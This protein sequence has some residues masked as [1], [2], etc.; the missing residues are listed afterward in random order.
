MLLANV[1]SVTFTFT[2]ELK[3][4]VVSSLQEEETAHSCVGKKKAS[5]NYTVRQRVCV[6]PVFWNGRPSGILGVVSL[7]TECRGSLFEEEAC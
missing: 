6:C 7:L 1:C 4:T 3:Q 2:H 5:V